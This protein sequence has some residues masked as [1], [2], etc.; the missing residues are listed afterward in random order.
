MTDSHTLNPTSTILP[1]RKPS[2]VR[3]ACVKCGAEATAACDCGVEYK[4]AAIRAAEA[5]TASPTRSD[6]AIA[7]EIGVNRRTVIKA[8]RRL[9]QSAP[10]DEKRIG[11]DGR[12]RKL[13]AAPGARPGNGRV[14]AVHWSR[15]VHPSAIY[16]D[17]ISYKT[18][19]ELMA[20]RAEQQALWKGRLLKHAQKALQATANA[21]RATADAET[22]AAAKAAADAWTEVTEE[23]KAR[24]AVEAHGDEQ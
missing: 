13:P 14:R 3:L 16:V 5:L 11:L 17:Q 20:L 12:T 9:V 2:I 1:F 4:P 19:P 10:V 18:D 15:R 7:E 21:Y 23:L 8:R 22:I 24:S 6:R